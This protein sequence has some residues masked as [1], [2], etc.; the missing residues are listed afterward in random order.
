[1]NNSFSRAR[2]AWRDRD[3]QAYQRLAKLQYE[4]GADFLTLN[5]DGTQSLSVRPQEMI[6]FVP[7]VVPAIQEVA[8]IPLAFDNPWCEFH[9]QCLQVYDSS[10][11]GPAIF[12][13]VAASRENLED[14]FELI[15]EYN[16]HV[17]VMASE[18]F[19]DGG[20]AQCFSAADV[21][22]T[23]KIFVEQLQTKTGR[24]NDQIIV[25]PGLAPISADTYGLI[26]MGLNAMRL[27]R[28][29]QDLSG[30]HL[31][32]GLTN[33]SFG[34]PKHIR[35]G[36]ENAYITK[37]V[38]SGLDF[39]LGNPEK[40]LHLLHESDRYVQVVRQALQEGRPAEGESQEEAGFRQSA[41]IMDL[42]R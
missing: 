38:A 23:A 20:S 21:H 16:T 22:Q 33:F 39:V 36:L 30:A 25:D 10:R 34:V 6:D 13:S 42:Y 5:L 18:K 14:M 28:D 1:M 4:L 3:V 9:R 35:E 15:A 8:P 2:R 32:V 31:S 24:T 26:N 29:D 37:A 12:N 17:I 41:R 40:D 7:D 27:I 19:I 11:S